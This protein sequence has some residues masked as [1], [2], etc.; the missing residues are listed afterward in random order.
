MYSTSSSD[1]ARASMVESSSRLVSAGPAGAK[2]SSKEASAGRVRFVGVENDWLGLP[3]SP[4]LDAS[5][6]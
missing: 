6:V 5:G 2:S 3:F 1:A 4:T